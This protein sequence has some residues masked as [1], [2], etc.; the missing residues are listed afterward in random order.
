MNPLILDFLNSIGISINGFFD[1]FKYILEPVQVDYSNSIL[2]NQIY[3]LSI[4]LFILS[5]LIIGLIT[6]LIS[7]LIIY[8]NMDRIRNFFNN[9][10]IRWYLDFNKK[11]MSIEIIILGSS[12]LYFMYTL[13]KGILFIATH[14]ITII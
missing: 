4:L 12:I 14:P 13:S 6:V 2:A 7:N 1:K 3:D 5:I 9:K 11:L 10:F 8:I